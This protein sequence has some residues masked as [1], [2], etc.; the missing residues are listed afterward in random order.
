MRA[1]PA[2]PPRTPPSGDESDGEL[3]EVE[4][5]V[6]SPRGNDSG[7]DSNGAKRAGRS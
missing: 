3:I 5:A 4:D 6:P 2:P 7:N 1:R